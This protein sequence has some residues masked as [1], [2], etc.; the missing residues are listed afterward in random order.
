MMTW[1]Y[2]YIFRKLL[3]L[4]RGII[5]GLPVMDSPHKG[6]VV[7]FQCLYFLVPSV[8]ECRGIQVNGFGGGFICHIRYLS[9]VFLEKRGRVKSDCFIIHPYEILILRC[10]MLVQL[11]TVRRVSSRYRAVFDNKGKCSKSWWRHQ[12]ETFSELLTLCAGNSSVT[13]WP[14]NSPHKGQWRVALM[15]SLICTCTTGWTNNRDAGDLR[16]HRAL[17]DVTE[18]W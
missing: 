6:L 11:S 5:Y 12:M 17:Y 15:F 2:W 7:L 16:R 13:W 1:W 9:W 4:R 10:E 3:G 14:V 8:D 18:M